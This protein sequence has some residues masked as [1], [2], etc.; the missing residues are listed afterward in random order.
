MVAASSTPPCTASR[1]TR[2]TM[3]RCASIAKEISS[4]S[5]AQKFSSCRSKGM[6]AIALSSQQ[7]VHEHTQ[8]RK[9]ECR[10]EKLGGAKYAQLR[11]DGL[12]ESEAGTSDRE[13]HGEQRDGS[14]EGAGTALAGRNAPG[15][16]QRKADARV[17]E[18][19]KSG[20]P[21]H[22]RKMARR[23]LEHHGF[24]NHRELEV[25]CRIVDGDAG[26]FG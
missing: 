23:V 10:G 2:F 25:S 7:Q 11:R 6:P 24:M 5:A 9:Q 12:D 20:R 14:E 15:D 8:Y 4:S 16:K 13:L 21:L 26:I 1:F 22:E 3:R 17:V 19:L 18:E